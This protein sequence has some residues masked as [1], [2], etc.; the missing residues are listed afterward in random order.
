MRNQVHFYGEIQKRDDA[1]RLV[2][3]YAST[4][5][6]DSDGEIILRS[7]LQEALDGYMEYGNVREMH[8][9]SAV[10]VT[11]EAEIDDRGLFIVVK[12]VDD[13][14]WKKVQEGVYKGSSIGGRVKERDAANRKVIKRLSLHEISWIGPPIPMRDLNS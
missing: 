14:A 2:E 9:A 4:E 7:G 10:G 8:S 12:V 3:G 5:A 11:K 13:D 1:K 6:V